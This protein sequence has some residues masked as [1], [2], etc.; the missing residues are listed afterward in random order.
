MTVDTSSIDDGGMYLLHAQ[1]WRQAWGSNLKP[2]SAF[3]RHG[4]SEH[5]KL[6]KFCAATHQHTY[7]AA[8]GTTKRHCAV[9]RTRDVPQ[10][11]WTNTPTKAVCSEVS[12][13]KTQPHKVPAPCK[14]ALSATSAPHLERRWLSS[15]FLRFFSSCEFSK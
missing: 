11:T 10:G 13:Q 8:L 14:E 6:S 5:V 12:A 2:T 1:S 15:F 3:C 4:L 9:S 7:V